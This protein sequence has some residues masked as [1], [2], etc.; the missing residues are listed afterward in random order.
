MPT[1]RYQK[2][3]TPKRGERL[4]VSKGTHAGC[5]GWF[6]A[7]KSP[8]TSSVH[9]I[10]DKGQDPQDDAQYTVCVRKESVATYTE[11]PSSVEELVI[12]EDPSVAFHLAALA[13]AVA[14]CGLSG[15]DK[16][17]ELVKMQIDKACVVQLE[18]GSK[19][20]YSEVVLRVEELRNKAAATKRHQRKRQ[21][22]N[23]N[24]MT[25]N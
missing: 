15:T 5:K 25:I 8:T 1:K 13:Q 20:K 17:L 9:I 16:L 14:Q 11:N 4:F 19:A 22:D 12:Q 10:I 6:N 7:A 2:K 3:A 23:E 24:E 18:K 21:G